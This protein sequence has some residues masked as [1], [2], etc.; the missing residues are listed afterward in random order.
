M[1]SQSTWQLALNRLIGLT[2]G[3][4]IMANVC[5]ILIY[6]KPEAGQWFVAATALACGVSAIDSWR[7]PTSE[8]RATQQVI[9]EQNNRN[10]SG[11]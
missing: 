9:V 4:Y 7:S 1:E 2:R 8:N 5:M 10:I 6:L 11:G 3:R